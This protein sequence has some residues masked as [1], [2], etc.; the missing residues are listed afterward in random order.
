M[1]RVAYLQSDGIERLL[2][3]R[4]PHKNPAPGTK[5]GASVC[6]NWFN[7]RDARCGTCLARAQQESARGCWVRGSQGWNKACTTCRD[8]VG[9]EAIA[10]THVD[11]FSDCLQEGLQGIQRRVETSC[12]RAPSE[13]TEARSCIVVGPSPRMAVTEK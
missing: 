10:H 12:A 4:M 6:C 13:A 7:L 11:D 8:L 3:L 9:P 1:L 5:P 2:L